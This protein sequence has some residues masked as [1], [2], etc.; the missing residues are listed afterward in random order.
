[1]PTADELRAF[2]AQMG[3]VP[4]FDNSECAISNNDAAENSEWAAIEN[5]SG[6]ACSGKSWMQVGKQDSGWIYLGRDH[7]DYTDDQCPSW[8]E[9]T[10]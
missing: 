6:A 10:E 9:T 2:I 7:S 4:L 1:M 8:S 5:P 3:N